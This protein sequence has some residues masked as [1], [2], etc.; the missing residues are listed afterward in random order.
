MKNKL[1]IS[2]CASFV[3]YKISY[4]A[5]MQLNGWFPFLVVLALL[6]I[7][8]IDIITLKYGNHPGYFGYFR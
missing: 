1:C 2:E 5:Y 4:S 7:K 6:V 3:F 8:T